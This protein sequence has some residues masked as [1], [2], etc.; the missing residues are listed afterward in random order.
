M[1]IINNTL[2]VKDPRGWRQA[3]KVLDLVQMYYTEEFIKI[4][5]KCNSSSSY[6]S[7]EAMP[8]Y[9]VLASIARERFSSFIASIK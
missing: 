6:K 8:E 5:K 3:K 4:A 2:K 9:K 7:I 1:S